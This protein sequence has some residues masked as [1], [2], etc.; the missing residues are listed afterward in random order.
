MARTRHVTRHMLSI[1]D[2]NIQSSPTRNARNSRRAGGGGKSAERKR[3]TRVFNA[4]APK[5]FGNYC[6]R[7]NETFRG[8]PSHLDTSRGC[9]KAREKKK[10]NKTGPSAI[11]VPNAANCSHPYVPISIY[12]DVCV[13]PVMSTRSGCIVDRNY[14]YVPNYTCTEVTSWPSVPDVSVASMTRFGSP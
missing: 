8:E 11:I 13:T 9:D 10:N 4:V 14:I 12:D 6:R 1:T 7:L 5:I 3:E 2:S